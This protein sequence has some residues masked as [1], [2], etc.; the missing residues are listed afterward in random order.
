MHHACWAPA[1]PVAGQIATEYG[2]QAYALADD[3]LIARV[4]EHVVEEHIVGWFQGRAEVGQRALGARSILGN[5]RRCSNLPRINMLKGREI[6]R[7]LAPSVLEEYASD[8]FNPA[9]P[10][11]SDFMLAACAVR[12]D[13]QRLLPAVVH[14]DGSARPQ[15]VSQA[16][17]P[18]YRQLLN[19]FR[20]AT[21]VPGGR[22]IGDILPQRTG[23]PCP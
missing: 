19:A 2:V 6:W 4:V 17:H 12:P 1:L 16:T 5:M 10:L 14:V 18:R 20:A 23:C 8:L 13:V 9:P 3:E 15:L 11:L 22:S 21:G 7:P